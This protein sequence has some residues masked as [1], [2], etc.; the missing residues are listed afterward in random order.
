MT[1]TAAAAPLAAYSFGWA[2]K[3]LQEILGYTTITKAIEATV[4]GIPDPLPDSFSTSNSTGLGNRGRY[5]RYIAERRT[6][7]L[8][9]FGAPARVVNARD[10]GEVEFVTM[11]FF[12]QL[13]LDPFIYGQLQ[14]P[15][16]YEHDGAL[17]H[18]KR[19]VGYHARKAA[20]TRI[21][22]K[23]KVLHDGVIYW[24]GSGNL[25][26]TSSG[27]VETHS[28]Q[29]NANNQSQLNGII[30]ASWALSNTNIPLHLR[31]LKKRARRLT[32]YKLRYA[33]Y[34]E[35]VPG[36]LLQ[37]QYIQQHFVRN[38]GRNA[39]FLESN[40]VGDLLDYTWVPAYE[41]FWEDQSAT[42]QDIW[43]A[44]QVVFTPEPDEQWWDIHE[45]S[46][47][48]PTS[49]YQVAADGEAAMRNNMDWIR[50]MGGY[51]L[52]LHNPPT[53]NNYYFDTFLPLLKN[54]DTIFQARV[55]F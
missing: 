2:M 40:E 11:H 47:P 26:P 28:F 4:N 50:G 54:P 27:A 3:H 38:P 32:G 15:N 41:A 13:P 29:V 17:Q 10:M 37:N 51:G 1:G 48:K 20:N 42:N 49:I 36:Y 31:L 21:A 5:R 14:S 43:N 9:Q 34:G 33:F 52:V 8:T 25:L 18:L 44:D 16:S 22:T 12:E 46:Y 30:G 53:C 35:N 23:L 45:G 6:M 19:Q 7:Q 55:A 39:D 24:D